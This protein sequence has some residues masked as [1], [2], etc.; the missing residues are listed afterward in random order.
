MQEIRRVLA[1]NGIAYIEVPNI[2]KYPS[3]SN[4]PIYDFFYEHINH[5][6][7]NSLKSL[8][9][10]HGFECLEMG[11]KSFDDKTD[12]PEYCL[13]S[14]IK[15]GKASPPILAPP[16]SEIMSQIYDLFTVSKS[17]S[18]FLKFIQRT[19]SPIH[20]WGLSSYM[21]YLLETHIFPNIS[22]TGL[23]DSDESKQ[24]QTI[25][26][27]KIESPEKLFKLSSKNT[28][29]IPEGPYAKQLAQILQAKNFKGKLFVL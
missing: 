15:L 13:Y 8:F 9:A 6:D 24:K 2:L 7:Q 10:I 20:I 5:F 28:I 11:T 17:I 22:V 14:V 23:Y 25:N 29:V 21:L 18:N 26:G 1:D 19:K 4:V 3:N 12:S 27:I 16:S